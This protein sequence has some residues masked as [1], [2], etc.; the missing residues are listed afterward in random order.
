M[1]TSKK[2]DKK[3]V[4]QKI[5]WLDRDDKEKVKSEISKMVANKDYS[6]KLLK[7]SHAERVAVLEKNGYKFKK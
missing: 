2:V 3:P 7:S 1:K 4:E 5:R 6:Q